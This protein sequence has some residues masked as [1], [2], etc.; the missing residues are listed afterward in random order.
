L[1][2]APR[3][4]DRIVTRCFALMVLVALLAALGVTVPLPDG[5]AN[6]AKPLFPFTEPSHFALLFTPLLL[7]MCVVASGL[8][9]LGLLLLGALVALILQN[10]TLIVGLVVVTSVCLS[11]RM[12][13]LLLIAGLAILQMDLSYYADRLDFSG[14][15][16][17][18]SNL[19]YVQGWQLMDES[20]SQSNGWGLGFQQLGVQG[21]NTPASQIINTL[22]G[23]DYANI[24]D[25]GFTMSKVISEFGI[26]G[27]GLIGIYLVAAWSAWRS[28]RLALQRPGALHGLDVFAC[29]VIVG[30]IVELLVRGTGYFT[31]TTILL[32]AALWLRHSRRGL[33][34]SNQPALAGSSRMRRVRSV[35]HRPAPTAT[36]AAPLMPPV[37]PP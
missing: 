11:R 8:R 19:V 36:P 28:L 21:S 14:D 1:S 16:Q 15:V 4:L 29:S 20:L 30:Y 33:R 23:G 27:L 24:L 9:R 25:G 3:T 6:Y 10:L 13:P 17:N 2:A 22:L 31:G 34:M 5:Q 35:I 7:Y 26:F 12:L 32:C 18:L 37:P